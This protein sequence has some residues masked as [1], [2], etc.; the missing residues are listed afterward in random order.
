LKHETLKGLAT[1]KLGIKMYR[2]LASLAN[3]QLQNVETYFPTV[4]NDKVVFDQKPLEANWNYDFNLYD[5]PGV[6]DINFEPS[7]E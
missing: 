7:L 3:E 1:I 2:E 5:I 4:I 6:W